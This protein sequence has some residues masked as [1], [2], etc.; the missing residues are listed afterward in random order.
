MCYNGGGDE[1]VCALTKNQI[2]TARI[3]GYTAEGAGILHTDGRAVFVP[4]AIRDELWEARILKVS[5]SA[6]WGRGERLLEGSPHRRES[7]CAAFP[8]CGGCALRHMDY[9]E[10]LDLKLRRVNDALER[11]GGTKLRIETILPAETDARKRR[12]VIFNVGERDGRPIAGFYR[13]R[14]HDIVPAE[15]CPAVTEESLR[16]AGAVLEWMDARGVP[17]YDEAAKRNGVRHIFYRSSRFSEKAVLTLTVSRSPAPGDLDTLVSRLRERCGELSGIVLNLNASRGNTVLAGEFRTL[18]GSDTLEEELL[19]L[20]F[21]LSPRSFFQV[22]P[23]QAERLY[24]KAMEYA[25]VTEGTPALDLYCGTGTLALCMAKRGGRVTGAE[26]VAPAVENARAN[27]EANGL[28]D[29]C[30]FLCADAGAAAEELRRR[31]QRPEVILVDPPRKGLSPEV[32][33]A[34]AGMEPERI[35]YVSCDPA[36]LARD[37]KS[38]EALRYSAVKGTAVDMFPRTGHIETIVLLQKLNS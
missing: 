8:R 1:K 9:E 20:R 19:G 3:D 5:A 35:V 31:G 22:N 12:K 29:R 33:A 14:S 38:F 11:I 28:S 15:D 34:A 16:C 26:V 23:P 10:E 21:R 36:T 37:L 2:V 6:V 17:A 7:D 24:E 30:E 27:A 4:G 32:I 18:W 13:A 25:A